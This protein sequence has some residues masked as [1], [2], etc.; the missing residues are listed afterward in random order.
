MCDQ[1]VAAIARKLIQAMQ[2]RAKSRSPEDLRVVLRLQTE[3]AHAVHVEEQEARE[4]DMVQALKDELQAEV[5]GV[6]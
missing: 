2:L 6:R 4:R 3:L 1:I 5:E